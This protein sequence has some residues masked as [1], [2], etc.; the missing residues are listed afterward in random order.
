[1]NELEA[2]NIFP[3]GKILKDR[4]EIAVKYSLI[5]NVA[6][7]DIWVLTEKCKRNYDTYSFHQYLDGT[8]DKPMKV[9]PSKNRDVII[10]SLFNM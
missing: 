10:Q 7:C 4:F 5:R 6:D 2:I 8:V 3:F 9:K 1:M